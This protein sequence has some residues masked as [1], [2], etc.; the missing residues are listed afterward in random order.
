MRT[1]RLLDVLKNA[2]RDSREKDEL[3]G[4]QSRLQSQSA[5]VAKRREELIRRVTEG[6]LSKN[7]DERLR[8]LL[9]DFIEEILRFEGLLTQP[10]TTP[11]WDLSTAERWEYLKTLRR[12]LS[13]IEQPQTF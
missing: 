1:V 8:A 2:G 12:Q 3:Y 11:S 7:G 4:L 5:A 6:A 10:Q 9:C 13:V